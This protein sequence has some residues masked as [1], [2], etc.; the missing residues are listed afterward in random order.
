MIIMFFCVAVNAMINNNNNNVN[1]SYL[2]I[3]VYITAKV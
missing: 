2:C 1:I 3:L